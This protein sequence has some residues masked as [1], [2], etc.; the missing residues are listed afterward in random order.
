MPPAFHR[1]GTKVHSC[2]RMANSSAVPFMRLNDIEDAGAGEAVGCGGQDASS[3]SAPPL[4]LELLEK[5]RANPESVDE[6]M[7]VFDSFIGEVA[8]NE[9]ALIHHI[10]FG[11]ETTRGPAR[12][13]L[14][15]LNALTARIGAPTQ[16]RPRRILL[17]LLTRY[18][19]LSPDVCTSVLGLR[20]RWALHLCVWV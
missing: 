17:L 4:S 6:A 16:A 10:Q 15:K 9:S 1:V 14:I 19:P 7:S 20:L 3:A 11:H 18:L 13:M 2:E 8:K 12:S 5:I